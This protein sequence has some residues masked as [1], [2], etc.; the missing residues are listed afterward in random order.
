QCLNQ[1][2]IVA[3]RRA[4]RDPQG[5]GSQR[6]IK[7]ARRRDENEDAGK[8]HEKQKASALLAP[9]RRPAAISGRR[10]VG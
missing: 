7:R 10:T 6:E 4:Y 1:F 2:L 5:L 3:A 9:Q 8:H